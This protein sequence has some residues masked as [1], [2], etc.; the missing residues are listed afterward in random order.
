MLMNPN[1]IVVFTGAGMSA[2]SGLRTFRDGDGLWRQYR[3][4]E[5]ASPEAWESHPEVVLEFYNERRAKAA[6]AEP[7]AGHK[8]IAELEKR[9]E[10][11]VVTQN[12]DDLHERAGSSWVIHVHGELRKARS[13]T[14][15]DYIRDIGGAPIQLG[16]LCPNGGQMRPHI[17]WFGEHI[18]N[19]ESAVK[20]IEKAGKV[21]VVGTSL[22]VYP[23]AGFIG[24]A[25]PA[26]EKWMVDLDVTRVPPGFKGISGSADEAVPQLVQRWLA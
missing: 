20:E 18:M 24:Y 2:P 12:V 17:V 1:K 4:E 6:A 7:N 5:V 11:V 16:D 15:D 10:V 19:A 3:F 26:A 14:D 22:V 23:A 9:Y 21:L 25:S 13:S 8:A